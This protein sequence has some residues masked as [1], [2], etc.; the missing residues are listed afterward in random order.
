MMILYLSNEVL[1]YIYFVILYIIS[2]VM[3]LSY[4]KNGFFLFL[5][6]IL[7]FYHLINVQVFLKFIFVF[8][9]GYL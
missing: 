6:V 8:T 3:K 1:H 2:T 9:Q 7:S 5:L 4:N